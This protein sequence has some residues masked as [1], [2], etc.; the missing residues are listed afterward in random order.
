MCINIYIYIHTFTYVYGNWKILVSLPEGVSPL[1]FSMT[2]R[3]VPKRSTWGIRDILLSPGENYL[4]TGAVVAAVLGNRGGVC[5]EKTCT[6]RGKFTLLWKMVHLLNYGWFSHW[7]LWF[8]HIYFGLLEA[9]N[10]STKF[11]NK[12]TREG[13]FPMFIVILSKKSSNFKTPRQVVHCK[14]RCEQWNA[15]I[16]LGKIHQN[17]NITMARTAGSIVIE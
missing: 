4:L 17:S 13:I 3:Q 10:P 7:T 16:W 6:L 12:Y 15:H 2:G 11:N 5:L 14:P 1:S 9:Q 8:F